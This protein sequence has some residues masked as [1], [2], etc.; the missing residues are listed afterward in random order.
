[1][2]NT[3]RAGRHPLKTSTPPCEWDFFPNKRDR[4]APQVGVIPRGR[5]RECPQERFSCLRQKACARVPRRTCRSASAYRSETRRRSQIPPSPSLKHPA[6]FSGV[7][8]HALAADQRARWKSAWRHR[9]RASIACLGIDSSHGSVP[10]SWPPDRA[11]IPVEAS[12]HRAK[13]VSRWR[14]GPYGDGP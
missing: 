8:A 4:R 7:R 2:G 13:E 1:M 10:R 12:L 6:R 11:G 5:Q 14:P 3:R 9:S